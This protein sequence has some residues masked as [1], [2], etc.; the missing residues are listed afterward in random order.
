MRNTVVWWLFGGVVVL[1]MVIQVIPYG[2]AHVN[3]RVHL[4]PAWDSPAT[5]ALAAR[6]CYDCHSNQT[7]WPWYSQIAP[8]SWLVQND[9]EEGRH[10]LNFSEWDRPQRKALEAA[11]RVQRGSMPPWYY[12][13]MHSKAKLS[14][15]ERQALVQGLKATLAQSR[16]GATK[17]AA[18]G[19]RRGEAP[20]S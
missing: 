18:Q 6:A 7:V 4:E 1:G 11:G 2:H 12:V 3:P 5:R 10:H 16:P 13:V 15:A 17:A 9:V 14:D 19:S 8:V 20:G